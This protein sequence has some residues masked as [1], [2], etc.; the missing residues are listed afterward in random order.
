M[1]FGYDIG[2]SIGSM[3]NIPYGDLKKPITPFL[4]MTN[5]CQPRIYVT[6]IVLWQ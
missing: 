3:K 5:L 1:I 2:E 4:Q 6:Y